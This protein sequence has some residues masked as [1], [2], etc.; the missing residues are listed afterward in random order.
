MFLPSGEMV[1][2]VSTAV[3]GVVASGTTCVNF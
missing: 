1:G 2:W 3:P